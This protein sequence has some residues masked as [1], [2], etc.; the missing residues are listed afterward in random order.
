MSTAELLSRL[1]ER[2]VRLWVE[3]GRLKCDAPPGALD[4]SLR[5]QLV[6]RKLELVAMMAG[7]ETTLTA[8]RSLV[9]LKPTGDQPPLF[10]RPGHNGDVFCY[11]A[12]VEH[13]DERRPLYGVEPR[14]LDGT[15][16]AETVEA[17]ARYEVE[18]IREFQPEGP[19]FLAG[20]CAG[21]SIA[22]ES[23]RQLVEAGAE[24]ARVLLLGSPFPGAYRAHWVQAQLRS[25]GHLRRR[26]GNRLADG[27]FIDGL[28]YLG[29][30]AGSRAVRL[31]E[32]PDPALVNRRRVEDVTMAAVKRYEPGFYAGRIDVVA[33]NKAWRHSGEQSDEWKRLARQTVEHAGPDQC[34]GDSMLHEPYVRDVAALVNSTLR[35][36]GQHA[37]D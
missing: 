15:P 3:E 35:D 27:S 20:Y 37:A 12:L 11:R 18:Q 1:R 4:D 9:P 5:A 34:D 23:A 16:P 24:V 10:A 28:N 14:G 21:G 8:P 13:L 26:H 36:E 6:A 7:A 22:F 30:R 32:R 31:A 19:Y 17:M 2:D 25:L 29:A 33:P